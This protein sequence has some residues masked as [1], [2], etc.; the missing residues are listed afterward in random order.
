MT[1]ICQILSDEHDN[2]FHFT[3]PDGRNIRK[4]M[5]FLYPFIADKNAWPYPPDVMYYEFFPNRQP[6]LLFAGLA[7][8]DAQYLDLWSKLN[9]DPENEE[10]I[11]NFPIRQPILW[12][13][14]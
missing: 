14:Q 4:G 6:C 9:P 7:Y 8:S 11:R 1:A 2:L 12:V 13:N 10:A 5:E 3:L